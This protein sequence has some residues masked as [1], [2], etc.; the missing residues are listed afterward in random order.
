MSI[1]NGT[2]PWKVVKAPDR[3]LEYLKTPDGE[4]RQP[5]VAG[6]AR[7][8]RDGNKLL[9]TYV[10]G[11]PETRLMVQKF[12]DLSYNSSLDCIYILLP[13][14]RMSIDHEVG[15]RHQ[16]NWSPFIF[17]INDDHRENLFIYGV[18]PHRIVFVNES[19]DVGVNKVH[20]VATTEFKHQDESLPIWSYGEPRGGTPAVLI[21]TKYGPRYLTFFHSQC[22]CSIGYILTY[23]FGAYLFDPTPPF[24]I[25]HWTPNPIIPKPLYDENNGWAF[26][27]IDYIVFPIGLLV[28]GETCY[29]SMGRNDNSGWMVKMNVSGLVDSMVAV[30]SKTILNKFSRH[31]S[32]EL[33]AEERKRRRHV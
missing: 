33:H 27:A 31:I 11:N 17:E 9:L 4:G 5:L 23:Y 15:V 3:Y 25:S 19:L 10:D 14:T 6:D 21:D 13:A 20:T 30:K 2:E 28:K 24:A 26:K 18:H 1:G 32:Y 7:I 16:K 22:K 8:Y 12:G 29:V